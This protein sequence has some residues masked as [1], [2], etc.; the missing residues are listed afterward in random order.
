MT[1]DKFG[2]HISHPKHSSADHED[3]DVILENIAGN[4]M[5]ELYYNVILTFESTVFQENSKK[6]LISNI[7]TC[8]VFFHESAMVENVTGYPN[9]IITIINE[10]EFTL[11]ELVNIQLHRGDSISFREKDPQ[12]T[13]NNLFLEFFLRVPVGINI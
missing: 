10:K 13:N 12:T 9:D 2:R 8:H 5:K 4:I 1:I 6:Y 7:K 3:F 11:S